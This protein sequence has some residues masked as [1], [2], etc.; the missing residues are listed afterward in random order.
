M[1]CDYFRLCFLLIHGGFY[2]D[3]DE[4]FLGASCEG[5]FQD[6]R[7]KA[8]PLC[9]DRATESMV[10]TGAFLVEGAFSPDW[11][12]YVGNDPLVAPPFHPVIQLA[13][14]RATRILLRE[15][16]H[17]D[18]GDTTGPGNL[19]V[20]LVRHSLN[21]ELVGEDRDFE[22]LDNWEA[23]SVSRWPLSYRNDVRN[24]RLWDPSV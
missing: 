17:L 14:V 13:L 22:L 19:T 9:Y 24:W 2:V 11:I 15:S 21:C 23:I 10:P 7:L 20:S 18:I 5:L 4:W 16:R 3:A 6:S 8:Q 12:Y 1:R